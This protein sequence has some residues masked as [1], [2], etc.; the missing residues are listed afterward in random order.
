[1]DGVAG[2]GLSCQGFIAQYP[3]KFIASGLPTSRWV[4]ACRICS[5]ISSTHWF[6]V[7]LQI[8]SSQAMWLW[9]CSL[10]LPIFPGLALGHCQNGNSEFSSV[11][12]KSRTWAQ[13]WLCPL[14]AQD[15]A[16]LRSQNGSMEGAGQSPSVE[17][18]R[19][20]N[21]PGSSDLSGGGAEAPE[22]A[23]PEQT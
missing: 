12:N 4:P 3:P 14:G 8:E 16:V 13:D 19:A 1:V 11:S 15:S 18:N 7:Y 10:P 9:V 6:A 2:S 21:Q 23:Q 5:L 20:V 17:S 22:L